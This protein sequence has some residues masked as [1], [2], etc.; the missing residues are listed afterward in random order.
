LNVIETDV[1]QFSHGVQNYLNLIH[2]SKELMT[3]R[4]IAKEEAAIAEKVLEIVIRE[5]F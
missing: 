4:K 5:L 2:P 1:E 3:G